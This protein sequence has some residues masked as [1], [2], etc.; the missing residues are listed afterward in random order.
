[1]GNERRY[2]YDYSMLCCGPIPLC[3]RVAQ[4]DKAVAAFAASGPLDAK[5]QAALPPS[6]GERNV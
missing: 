5:W 6:A 2:S 3:Y 1:M 4:P